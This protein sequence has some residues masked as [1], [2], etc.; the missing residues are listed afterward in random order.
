MAVPAG[1][2]AAFEVVESDTGCE[3][4][5]VVFDAPADFASRTRV[6]SGVVGGRM[7]NLYL[8]GSGLSGGHSA[9]SHSSGRLP[10]LLRGMCRLAG[11]TRMARKGLRIVAVGI[12][13]LSDWAPEPHE[14]VCGPLQS[15]RQ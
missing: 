15:L 7:D 5:V 1:V 4:T 12:S 10:S 13:E 9:I 11:R 6:L 8:T 14:G 2:V 3:F